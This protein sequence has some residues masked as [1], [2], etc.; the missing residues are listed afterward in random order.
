MFQSVPTK[1]ARGW[2]P[3]SAGRRCLPWP[4]IN[5]FHSTH[6]TNSVIYEYSAASDSFIEFQSSPTQGAMDGKPSPWAAA[7]AAVANY[8]DDSTC[9]IN[10]VIYEYSAASDS[11]RVPSVPAG[12]EWMGSLLRGRSPDVGRGINMTTPLTRSTRSSSTR[13]RPTRS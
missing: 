12:R 6:N 11:R 5:G 9:K 7:N 8:S 2:K 4:I 10:S 3:F 13:R 1:G